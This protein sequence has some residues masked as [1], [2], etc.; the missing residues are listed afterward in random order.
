MEEAKAH[1]NS[2]LQASLKAMQHKIDETN[3]LLVK[4]REAAKKAIQEA[5][6]VI[7]ETEI[8]VEDTKKIDSLNQEVEDLKVSSYLILYRMHD[9]T[10]AQRI[11]IMTSLPFYRNNLPSFR[12]S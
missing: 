7:K 1:E 12:V 11:N 5:P 4:E 6:P 10:L 8:V 3:A 2:K 9:E